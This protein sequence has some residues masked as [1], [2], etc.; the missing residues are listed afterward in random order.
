MEEFNLNRKTISWGVFLLI[1]ISVLFFYFTLSKKGLEI[2]F[3]VKFEY[4]I[5]LF[6]LWFLYIL[7]DSIK[8]SLL[9]GVGEHRISVKTAFETISI[10]IFLAAITPFQMSGFPVQIYYLYKKKVNVGEG[11]SYLLLRGMVTFTGIVILAFPYAYILRNTFNGIMKGI[12]LYAL[13]VVS[14]IFVLYLLV[15][16][17]PK[18]LKRY[19]KGKTYEEFM[20]LRTVFTTSI[21]DRNK[22]KYIIYA[23][24]STIIS[25]VFLGIIPYVVQIATQ[26]KRFTLFKSIGYEMI[27]LSSL[28]FTPT[29]GGSGIAEASASYIF[30]GNIKT[31]YV[32]PF[33]VL[34]RFF[35]FYLT[36]IIGGI[37]F[38]KEGRNLLK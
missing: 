16:F 8:F 31:E 11:T 10:G 17:A 5:I 18:F 15:L 1:I 33:I 3:S 13:F 30:L 14:S 9:S 22:R 28:F 12:Y 38:I 35:T 2:L 34:W 7:F 26:V 37:V 29:P 4:L 21:K 20:V 23:F 24:L 36:A 27:V 25:L 32:F 19:I 6:L